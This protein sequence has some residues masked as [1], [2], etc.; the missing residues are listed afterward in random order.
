MKNNSNIENFF[1]TSSRIILF[2][3][4]IIVL[5]ALVLKFN[6]SSIKQSTKSN[7]IITPTI[8][9]TTRP[10][11]KLN[12]IDLT[13]PYICIYKLKDLD[14]KIYIKNKNIYSEINS[15]GK[16]SKYLIKGDCFYQ[17]QTKSETK[18]TCGLSNYLP[19]IESFLKNGVNSVPSIFKSYI[20]KDIDINGVL[21]SCKKEKVDDSVFSL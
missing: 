21:N 20:P 17:I 2:V 13:G 14:L 18:K 7:I 5:L 6:N 10:T 1:S 15:K 12:P 4:I 16:I 3:P 9:I 19:Y 8:L 11:A